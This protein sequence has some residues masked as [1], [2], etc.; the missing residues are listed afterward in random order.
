MLTKSFSHRKGFFLSTN[1]EKEQELRLARPLKN[2]KTDYDAG[3]NQENR[4]RA[5]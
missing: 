4:Q 2:R 5:Q 3:N 1:E